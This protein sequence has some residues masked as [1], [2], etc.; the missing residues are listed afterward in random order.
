[1]TTPMQPHA[2]SPQTKNMA[3]THTHGALQMIDDDDWVTEGLK[4]HTKAFRK[5]KWRSTPVTTAVAAWESRG[6]L[7]VHAPVPRSGQV[8]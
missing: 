1:M 2:I 8:S 7:H 4:C 5:K 3:V 6:G